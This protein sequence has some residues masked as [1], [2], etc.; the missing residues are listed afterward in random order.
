MAM[1]NKNK[2]HSSPVPLICVNQLLSTEVTLSVMSTLFRMFRSMSLKPPTSLLEPLSHD[3]CLD[4]GRAAVK[5]YWERSQQLEQEIVKL[6][7]WL[8]TKKM[9]RDSINSL[10]KI[11][12]SR[13]YCVRNGADGARK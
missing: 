13:K 12:R 10:Q 9:L 1:P 5:A 3:H 2:N 7:E 4:G 8:N 11:E 6:D